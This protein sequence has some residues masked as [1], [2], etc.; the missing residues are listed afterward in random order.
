MT[1]GSAFVYPHTTLT[2]TMACTMVDV[3]PV[4]GGP[5]MTKGSTDVRERMA[6]MADLCSGLGKAMWFRA[7]VAGKDG[8]TL[9]AASVP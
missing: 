7:S 4:P 3:F 6:T 8:S 9:E 5:K 2:S 1:R